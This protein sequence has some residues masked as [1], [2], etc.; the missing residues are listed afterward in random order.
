MHFT[1]LKSWLTWLEQCHPQ[2]IELGLDRIRV[3]AAR[4]NLLTPAARVITVAGTNGKGSCV[5]SAAALLCASG[6]RTGVY[7]SPHLMRYNE[8]IVID[9]VAASDEEICAAFVKI[10]SATAGVSLTYFEFGTLAAIEIFTRRQV[11]VMV[12]EV[13]LG[14]RLDAVNILSPD[15]A[16]ITSIDIDH[17]AWLGND[18]ESIGFEKAGIMRSGRPVVCADSHPPE[19]LLTV[20]GDVGAH[21]Y[22]IDQDFGYLTINGIWRWWGQL[23]EEGRLE[24]ESSVLPGL[25]LPS[26]AAA[27]QAVLLLGIQLSAPIVASTL[28]GLTMPG[29]FQQMEYCGRNLILDVAHNPAASA[30]LCTR[31]LEHPCAGRTYA[32][33][34]MMSDKDHFNSLRNLAPAIDSWYLAALPEVPRAA[35]IGQMEQSLHELELVAEGSGTLAECLGLLCKTATAADRIVVWG[36]FYTVAAALSVMLPQERSGG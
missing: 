3:V 32:L 33:A 29:R 10:Q 26:V 30:Y 19:S 4:L 8:R 12:L 28:G 36:S 20:A 9:G 25:P 14:G 2:E 17:S 6:L 24:L 27:I 7:T 22:G 11:D 16:V 13:G 34:A 23:P 18:R 5:T 15:V 31:L 1:S 35:S 21:W